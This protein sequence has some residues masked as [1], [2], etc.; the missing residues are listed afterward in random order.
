MGDCQNLPL[1]SLYLALRVLANR[2]SFLKFY[3]LLEIQTVLKLIDHV[4]AQLQSI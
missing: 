1:C 3:R 4:K 2:Y